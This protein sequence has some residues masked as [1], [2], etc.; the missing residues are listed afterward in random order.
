MALTIIHMPTNLPR[1]PPRPERRA[2]HETMGTLIQLNPR[3]NG[4]INGIL[5]RLNAPSAAGGPER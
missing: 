4:T 5:R 3:L 1:R 2:A